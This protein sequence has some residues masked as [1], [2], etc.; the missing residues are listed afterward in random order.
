MEAF[1]IGGRFRPKAR[2]TNDDLPTP[3]APIIA[4]LKPSMVEDDW[5]YEAVPPS[6]PV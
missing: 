4:I 1:D 2:C 6:V 3:V 5:D